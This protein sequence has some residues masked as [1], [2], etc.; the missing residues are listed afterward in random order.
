M[1]I[2]LL[3]SILIIPIVLIGLVYFFVT[4]DVLEKWMDGYFSIP[5]I[6]AADLQLQLNSS[7]SSNTVIFDVRTPEEFERSHL[8][9]AIR[10]NPGMAGAEFETA[11]GENV[12]GKR[13]VFYCSVGA[14]SSM[15]AERVKESLSSHQTQEILNLR[16]GIFRWYNEGL[17]VHNQDGATDDV[18]PYDL[19]WGKLL[20]KRH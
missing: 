18:H 1:K 17:P 5:Q 11:F 15:L 8:K 12:H 6:E 20:K 4:L 9:S 13:L 7:D 14:R 2:S 3:L 16:G 10:L 19:F